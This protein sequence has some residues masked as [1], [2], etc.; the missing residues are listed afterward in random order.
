M[1]KTNIWHTKLSHIN[2]RRLK[3][4]QSMSKCVKSFDEKNLIQCPSRVKEKQHKIKFLK[5]ST[6]RTTK[7]FKIIHSDICGP[8]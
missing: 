1:N 8:F 6:S 5:E 4:I 2:Q 7:I 3:E